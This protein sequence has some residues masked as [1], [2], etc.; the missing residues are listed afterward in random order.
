MTAQE[1]L[2]ISELLDQH[3]IWQKHEDDRLVTVQIT[4]MDA[5]HLM[6][7]RS[8]L[9]RHAGRIQSGILYSLTQAGNFLSGEAALDAIDQE[10]DRVASPDSEAWMK[11][12]I[13]FETI[14][15]RLCELLH[16]TPGRLAEL[17]DPPTP[18]D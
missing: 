3:L 4:E 11:E 5:K 18:G 8:W 12:Q 6:N 14:D 7:L 17:L 1:P 2:P 16:E 15:E 9:L 13:L 10:W